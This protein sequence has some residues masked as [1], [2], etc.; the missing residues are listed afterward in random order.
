[1]ALEYT[2]LDYLAQQ[3]GG[4]TDSQF[5]ENPDYSNRERNWFK[6]NWNLFALKFKH[7]FSKRTDFSLNIFGLD[8]SR[9]AL[10]FRENRVSLVDDPSEPR[11][12]LI[13]NFKNWGAEARVLTRYDLKNSEHVLLLGAKYYQTDNSQRQGPGTAASNAD[14][15]FD[16]TNFPNYRRQTNFDF[17]NKNVAFFG[18]NIFNITNK[19]S[20]T[21]GFRL[22]YINTGAD[23]DYKQI[24]TDLNDDAYASETF[25]ENKQYERNFLL[26]GVGTSYQASRGLELY[27]NFSQNYRSVTFSDIRVVNPVFQIDPNITDEEGFTAD[28]G[29]RGK[30]KQLLN[31]DINVFGLRYNKRIGEVLKEETRI[32]EQGEKE[33]TGRIVR[34]KGNIGDA[35]IYGVESFAELNLMKTFNPK[36][37]NWKLNI[38][39]NLSYTQSE[40]TSSQENN[41]EGNEVE[42]IPH[43]N[44]KTGIGFGYKNLLGSL[45][46]T[47]LSKQYSDATNSP[48]DKNDNQSGIRGAI[49]SYGILDLSL[50]YK[51][52]RFILE[53]GINNLLDNSY[54][55]RRATGYPGPGIIPAQRIT[56]YTTL[57]VKI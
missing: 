16:D 46:Y 22:E 47:Y 50:S 21:P 45:Q 15:I 23:G 36:N 4:L 34:F 28:I 49:P 3:S 5:Y 41:V 43:I 8:A 56:W 20:V 39:S 42:F 25:E 55:T 57:Q 1:M 27:A 51:Y 11:E 54:F 38:F 18:E 52:K 30:V 35:F 53:T 33:S 6:V 13:D 17:P 44:L 48:Q 24:Y 19:L 29:F 7:Q 10:G 40:Y 2:F 32:N 12:L 26:L 14:F 37:K 9:K 31:Y